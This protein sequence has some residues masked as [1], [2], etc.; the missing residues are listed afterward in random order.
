MRWY[1]ERFGPV[2]LAITAAVAIAVALLQ[3]FGVL[4]IPGNP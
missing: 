2:I 4:Q 1:D 3:W